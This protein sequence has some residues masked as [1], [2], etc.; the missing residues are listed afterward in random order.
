MA[1]TRRRL[2]ASPNPV[3]PNLRVVVWS[4][5]E[6]ASNIAVWFV[7]ANADA[8]VSDRELDQISFVVIT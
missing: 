4:A 3:P 1:S 2:I 8:C 5:C 6:K 7:F